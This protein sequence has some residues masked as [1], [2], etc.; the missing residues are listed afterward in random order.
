MSAHG[1]VPA[2][3]PT[4]TIDGVG[5]GAAALDGPWQFHIGDDPSWAKAELD[6]SGWEQITADTTWGAQGHPAYTGFA[7]YRKH[8][9][10]TLAPGAEPDLAL[11]IHHVD[12]IYELYWNGQLVGRYGTM[13]PHASYSYDVGAQTFGLGAARDGVL[14]VRVWKA[15]LYSFDSDQLGGFQD[16]PLVGSPTAIAEHKAVL[17]YRWLQSRQYTFAIASLRALIF[18]LS[19]LAW[20]R[21]REQRVLL[22]MAATTGAALLALVLVNLRLPIPFDAAIGTLQPVLSV[23][24]IGLWYLLLYLLRLDERPRMARFTRNLALVDMGATMLDGAL[25]LLNWPNPHIVG[26]VQGTDGLLTAVFTVAELYPLVLVGCALGKRLSSDRWFLAI[27]A[28][29]DGMLSVLRIAVQQ[30]SRYTHWTL[31][32]RLAAPLFTIRGNVFVAQTLADTLLLLAIIYAVYRSM[33]EATR[34][35]SSL[36]QEFRSARELQRVL[37]PEALPTLPGF[38]LTSAYRPAQEVGGDFFQVIPLE[39]EDAGATLILLGD[40]SGK[41]LAAAMTVSLIVGAVRAITRFIHSPGPVLTEL[42]TRLYGRMRGGFATCLALR[43]EPDGRCIFASAGHPS[44][45]VNERALGL[46]GALPLG[47]LP[48]VSYEERTT[49][50]REGDQCTLYTDG[51]LEARDATG[52]IFSFERL[53]ALFSRAPSATEATDAAVDFGQEDDITVVTLTKRAHGYSGA[54]RLVVPELR[55]S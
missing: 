27:A 14:A 18:A 10:L 8:I 51:L 42:N 49:M 13:P 54:S 26:W 16:A 30:G 6:E 23:A 50:M 4:L 33:R 45:Y 21:N 46:D 34:R 36:E 48:L 29:L 41:G 12:D 7:W 35:Q 31:G 9:H 52:A 19:L 40:V 55:A 47:I 32:N 43:I 38:D 20:F 28:S 25:V 1:A 39:G 37:I 24:D 2:P 3:A 5:K 17:D 11:F 22:A 53:D 44:P 15:P